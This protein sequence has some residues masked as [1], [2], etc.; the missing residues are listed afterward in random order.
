[1]LNKI[2]VKFEFTCMNFVLTITVVI[3]GTF[4]IFIIC[5]VLYS[6]RPHQ[7]KLNSFCHLVIPFH[8]FHINLLVVAEF[9][10][11]KLNSG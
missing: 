2:F 11:I 8:Y 4:F 7:Y 1:M 6:P 9:G 5:P 10:L 3:D